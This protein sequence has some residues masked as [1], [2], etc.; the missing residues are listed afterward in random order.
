[1]AYHRFALLGDPV[2][3]SR[4]P[5]IHRVLLEL[6]GLEGDYTTVRAGRSELVEAIAELRDGSWQGLN[7]TMPLK[8]DAAELADRLTP[9]AGRSLSVNT[10]VPTDGAVVGHSTD[11]TAF[12]VLFADPRFDESGPVLILGAGDSAAAALAALGPD[13]DV[14]VSARRTRAARDLITRLAPHPTDPGLAESGVVP[15]GAQVVGALVVNTT[16]LGMAGDELPDGVL[17]AAGGLIDLPYA[18][19]PTPA[20]DWARNKSIPLAD[21]YE[22]LV[23]Q[24]IASFQLWTGAQPDYGSVVDRLR[25]T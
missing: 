3:H 21:G 7:V 6:C 24:A 8:R 25:K 15:W 20:A 14:Y 9:V 11:S 19:G 23:R 1:M 4:S 18:S 22:F 17:A 10:L 16:P 13:A 5:E 12:S 2:G